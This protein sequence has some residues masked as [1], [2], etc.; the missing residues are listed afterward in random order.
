MLGRLDHIGLAVHDLEAAI[1]LYVDRFGGQL[2][3]REESPDLQVA[4]V[5]LGDS[6]LELMAP[7]RPGTVIARFLERRGE[8]LHHLA[9]EVSDAGEAIRELKARGAAPI[10]ESPRA[11]ARQSQIAF[12][13]PKSAAGVLV[14]I[15]QPTAPAEV[16][17]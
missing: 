14:E 16:G 17:Q 4:F 15:V 9:Y 8:G 13:H 6:T 2:E 12:F 11:G 1:A 5:R 7:R 10:D 3:E